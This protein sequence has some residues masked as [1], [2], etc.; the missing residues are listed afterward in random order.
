ML[1]ALHAF[2]RGSGEDL[3]SMFLGL[4]DS[5]L[6]LLGTAELPT[7]W[8]EA[9]AFMAACTP[10][11]WE[12]L[13]EVTGVSI[14]A[15]VLAAGDEF[16]E[17]MRDGMADLRS[18]VDPM[19][20]SSGVTELTPAIEAG[21]LK[22]APVFLGDGTTDDGVERLV[23]KVGALVANPRIQVMFDE[24]IAGLARAMIDEGVIAPSRITLEG[25]GQA[26]IG[27]GLIALLPAFDGAPMDELLDLRTDLD[28]SLTRYRRSVSHM[29]TTMRSGPFDRDAPAEVEHLFRTN[30]LPVL[31]EVREGMADHRLVLELAR[32]IGSDPRALVSCA[33]GPWVGLGMATTGDLAT[34]A[35]VAAGAMT[36]AVGLGATAVQ[37]RSEGQEP[38]R[39]HDLFYLCE[40]DRRLEHGTR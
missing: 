3:L 24:T 39:R 8:R 33:V 7:G 2:S 12:A 25:A 14:P 5:T 15:E 40:L 18:R 27:S 20:E 1:G 34:W 22:L 17:V 9:A 26:A 16:R 32:M 13:G 36:T 38:H 6:A 19:V 4:D 31:D 23:A 10:A 11:E 29:A 21:L 30:V 28:S 35:S 37:R